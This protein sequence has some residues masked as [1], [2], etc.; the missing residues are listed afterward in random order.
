MFCTTPLPDNP[1]IVCE[2]A[3]SCSV[4]S[5]VTE[6]A[7]VSVEAWPGWKIDDALIV[8]LPV[9]VFATPSCVTRPPAIVM[10]PLP[11]HTAPAPDHVSRSP[12]PL[13]VRSRL[14]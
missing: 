9:Q 3:L 5:A 14:I 8:M 12:P 11:D 1:L 13:I 6:F 10:A 7:A 4:P 2:T